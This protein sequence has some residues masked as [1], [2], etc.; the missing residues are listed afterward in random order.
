MLQGSISSLG[1][2]YIVALE[3]VNCVTGDTLGR[4]EAEANGR[5]NVLSALGKAA[6]RI[7]ERLGESLT[8][9]QRFD[10]PIDEATTSSVEAFKAFSLGDAERAHS[11]GQLSSLPY[12]KRAIELDPNF[13]LA[14]ARAGQVYA[15]AGEE[16]LAQRYMLEAYERRDR[17]SESEKFYIVAHYHDLVT[18][19]I[20]KSI[21]T[22]ELWR[23]TYPRDTTPPINLGVMD[24]F[25]GQFDKAAEMG[26]VVLQLDP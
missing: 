8:S 4:E 9:V 26:R 17:V 6:S 22:Y 3:A 10:V 7:R 12:Y 23:K 21:E 25:I 19:N 11:S 2:D 13:A 1:S 16:E 14:Y 15:F 24:N 18:R 20:D 5:E